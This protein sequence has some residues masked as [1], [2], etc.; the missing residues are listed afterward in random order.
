MGY[1]N[2]LSMLPQDVESKGGTERS[3]VAARQARVN[4]DALV[5]TRGPL[6]VW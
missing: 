6:L 5:T 1:G 4:D 3:T 2:T